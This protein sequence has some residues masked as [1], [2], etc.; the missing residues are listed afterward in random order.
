MSWQEE[1]RRL[2]AEL[3]EGTISSSEHRRRREDILAEVSGAPLVATPHSTTQGLATTSGTSTS[4]TDGTSGSYGSRGPGGSGP[5]GSGSSGTGSGGTGGIGSSSGSSGSSSG[6]AGGGENTA[7]GV[8]IERPESASAADLTDLPASDRAPRESH[9]AAQETSGWLAANPAQAA[10]PTG[11]PNAEN[12]SEPAVAEVPSQ[13]AAPSQPSQP[14]LPEVTTSAAALLATTKRTT[15]PSPADERPTELLR[16]PDLPP[17]PSTTEAAQDDGSRR[18]GLTWVAISG[19]VFL[20]L[21]AVIG[22]AWWLGQDRS[23]PQPPS[24]HASS[25]AAVEGG[26][27]ADR[28]P[29]L[30]GEQS[31]NNSTMSVARGEE[32]GLYPERVAEYF[33]SHGVTEVIV[34]GS[35]D[36]STGYLLLVLHAESPAE[37][38]NIADHLY[39][40]TLT[41]KTDHGEGPIRMASGTFGKSDVNGAWYASGEYA[42][43]L[44]VTQPHDKS[45]G[46]LAERLQRT[47]NSL[48]GVL[49]AE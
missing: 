16:L 25:D 40:T 33:T 27:L 13:P 31:P 37:A 49:P 41:K 3:A 48:R 32:L 18:T 20:A 29:A 39:R 47:V 24:A 34:R 8:E 21:G 9:E 7:A 28:L 46:T 10:S 11:S 45:D 43:A 36:D 26:Q 15:A 22:G 6:G 23:E 35:V 30:P 44:V 19:A 14:S 12:R 1:L 42:V 4:G 17:D 2:D 38:G 5:G